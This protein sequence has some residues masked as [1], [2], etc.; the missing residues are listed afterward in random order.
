MSDTIKLVNDLRHE[1]IRQIILVFV[2]T[3]LYVMLFL[4]KI[5]LRYKMH[6]LES[7]L[8]H[9]L[10]DRNMV[11]ILD[12]FFFQL[13]FLSRDVKTLHEGQRARSV[14]H[15]TGEL[16]VRHHERPDVVDQN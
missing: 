15:L 2:H 1:L 16:N 7:S 6:V 10:S 9:S 4:V 14:P 13:I 12:K 8:K 11:Q 5:Q 3:K